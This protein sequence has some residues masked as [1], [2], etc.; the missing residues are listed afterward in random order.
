METDKL[1]DLLKEAKPLYKRRKRQRTMAKIT[2]IVC[3]PVF[4]FSFLFQIYTLGNDI[5]VAL[6]NNKLQNELLVDSFGLFGI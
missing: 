6:D 4:L 2:L 1:S 5:Y 3:A